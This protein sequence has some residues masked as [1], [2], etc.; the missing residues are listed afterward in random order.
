MPSPR[1][2]L[3]LLLA[4]VGFTA[5]G[6]IEANRA[7]R[8]QRTV[9]EHA[10]H[11]YAGFVAWSYEQHL[12]EVFD[13]GTQ[14]A[15][16]PVNHGD[17]VHMMP[18]VPTA[19]SLP[20]FIPWDSKCN[21]HRS[22]TGINAE[23]YFAWKLG[24]DTL[25]FARNV[26]PN[27]DEGWEVDR[28][29]AITFPG[30]NRVHYT[31]EERKW[32]NDTLTRQIRSGKSDSR[33]PIVIAN[34]DSATRVLVYTL[35]PTAWGDTMVY[36][37]EYARGDLERVLSGVM[38]AGT[39]LPATFTRGRPTRDLVQLR[40]T[41]ARGNVM[42]ESGNPH[43]WAL[44]D[45]T[46][47]P[48]GFGSL[49]VRAQINPAVAESLIIGG[50][51]RSRLPFLIGLLVVS[52][53]L[54]VVAYA[55]MRREGEL[56]RLRSD[57]VASISH[58][59]RTP[60]AQMRLYLETLKLGR[61]RTEQERA[62]SIDNAERETT[63][64]Q[65]LVERVLEFSRTGHAQQ[66]AVEKV[67]VQLEVQR[68]VNE[69]R[70][71]AASRSAMLTTDIGV[72]PQLALRPA[73]LRHLV[74]NLLDNA[75]KYGPRGQPVHVRVH[76]DASNVRIEVSDQGAGIP[77]RDRERVWHAYERGTSAGHTAGSG[78]GLSIVRE[79]AAQHDGRVWIETGND[80]VGTRVVIALPIAA[81]N[82]E[83]AVTRSAITS[84]LP[85]G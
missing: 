58:E 11:D 57:F 21:C 63:R 85:S 4:S 71:L 16:G 19:Q 20:H 35:M 29:V 81:T 65:H 41:D 46:R 51:P 43:G 60:L 39:L 72:V 30:T 36:G 48:K 68:I 15:L 76:R 3:L 73:A 24:S 40:V 25:G 49:L 18:P 70:P 28:P 38:S 82:A 74:L 34:H 52:A 45:S 26:H 42:F 83:K 12:R 13:A 2:P 47:L 14:E 8:S 33:F 78:L 23:A 1:W 37:A 53:A 69:F 55:Q 62:W 9:A 61:F 17:G 84:P 27:P 5:L 6:V 59:L 80:G 31:A 10:L 44:D 32:I 79:V 64:L 66:D 77:E 75:V 22:H 50:L 67:D 56:A 7:I 54:A